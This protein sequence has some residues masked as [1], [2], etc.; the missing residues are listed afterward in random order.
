M[1]VWPCRGQSQSAVTS[2]LASSITVHSISSTPG[3]DIA[4]STAA[5]PYGLPS[6]LLLLHGLPH[7][8]C[9]DVI[10]FVH[11]LCLSVASPSLYL[12]CTLFYCCMLSFVKLLP[13]C[14]MFCPLSLPGGLGRIAPHNSDKKP[15]TTT[16]EYILYVALSTLP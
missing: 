3:C 7:I 12:F 11:L 4:A 6:V 16:P 5:S 9:A 13:C 8:L 10:I 14:V 15:Y 1:A 2:S